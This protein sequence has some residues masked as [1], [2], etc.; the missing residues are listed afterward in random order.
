M[1]VL[2]AAAIMLRERTD[3]R[4]LLPVLIGL[5]RDQFL[6][7]VHELQIDVHGQAPCSQSVTVQMAVFLIVA[8]MAGRY[9]IPNKNSH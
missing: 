2:Y 7:L 5:L 8:C 3:R 6:Q 9:D 4:Q 1:I